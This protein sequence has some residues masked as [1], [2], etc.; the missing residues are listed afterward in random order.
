[1]KKNLLAILI[2]AV[3]LVNTI[4]TGILMFTMMTT[5][6]KATTLIADI[7]AA[8][9]LEAGGAENFSAGAAGNL[10]ISSIATFSINGDNEM[11]IALKKGDDGVQHY[12]LVDLVISMNTQHADYATYGTEEALTANLSLIK[13]K[14]QEVIS[15]H[16]A[17]EA[18]SDTN[19]IREELVE[20]LQQMY[21]S[22]FIYDVN[23][24][25]ILVQ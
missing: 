25:Q 3:L 4:M 14:I 16:T 10:D 22:N 20:A 6:N 17:E 12:A 15:N 13:S 8:L 2:L 7:A 23:F 5:N 18:N 11:T 9:E 1:M 21:N 24:E 19:A